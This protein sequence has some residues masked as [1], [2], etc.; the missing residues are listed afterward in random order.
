METTNNTPEPGTL[1]KIG[2]KL[3]A[4]AQAV[5]GKA[6]EYVV[7]PVGNALGLTEEKKPEVEMTQSEKKQSRKAAVKAATKPRPR[8]RRTKEAKEGRTT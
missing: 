4:A 7:Q 8:S 6:D 2:G 5:A 1:A 3:K